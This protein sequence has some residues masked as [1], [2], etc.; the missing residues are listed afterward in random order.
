MFVKKDQKPISQ[1]SSDRKDSNEND[2]LSIMSHHSNHLAKENLLRDRYHQEK[3][4]NETRI[5]QLETER[6]ALKQQLKLVVEKCKDQIDSLVDENE[7]LKKKNFELISQQQ[8]KVSIPNE[9][10]A[11]YFQLQLSIPNDLLPQNF[12]SS[13]VDSLKDYL[14]QLLKLHPFQDGMLPKQGNSLALSELETPSFPE[15]LDP[16]STPTKKVTCSMT[17]SSIDTTKNT[18]SPY[19]IPDAIFATLQN[20]TLEATTVLME[21]KKVK[22]R[23]DSNTVDSKVKEMI[24]KI[25]EKSPTKRPS[26]VLK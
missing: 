19:Q 1:K 23:E 21:E 20:E 6:K 24:Q 5:L 9:K 15:I 8:Q 22:E 18:I 17:P 25:E 12:S 7:S 4:I 13:Q 16:I 2:Y 11:N 14:F 3:K 26:S 10:S